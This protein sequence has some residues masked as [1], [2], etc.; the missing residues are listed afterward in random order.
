MRTSQVEN[1]DV[2][3]EL[4]KLLVGLEEDVL[5]DVFGVL[6]VLRDVLGNAKDLPVVLANQLFES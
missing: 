3:L 4:V 6:T 5:G 2:A 1:F